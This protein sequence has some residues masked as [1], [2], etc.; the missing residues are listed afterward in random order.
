MAQR[1]EQLISMRD[2]IDQVEIVVSDLYSVLHRRYTDSQSWNDYGESTYVGPIG[3]D[4]P[5]EVR[6]YVNDN[7]ES[8]SVARI[9]QLLDYSGISPRF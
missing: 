5:Q 1:W 2:A 7:C 3:G 6:Y 4:M 9:W 8:N